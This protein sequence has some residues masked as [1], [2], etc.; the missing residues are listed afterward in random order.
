[1]LASLPWVV[2]HRRQAVITKK[3][4]KSLKQILCKFKINPLQLHRI[5]LRA[6]SC[7]SDSYDLGY[8]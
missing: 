6:H 5:I 7:L 1:M 2:L 3:G 8:E 4:L